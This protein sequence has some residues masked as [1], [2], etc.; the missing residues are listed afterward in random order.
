MSNIIL[1]KFN[2][3]KQF[4]YYFLMFNHMLIY[5]EHLKVKA[6]QK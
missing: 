2:I 6:E 4:K 1:L 3:K 5:V